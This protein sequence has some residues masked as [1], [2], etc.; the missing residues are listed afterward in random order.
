MFG[1]GFV[2]RG[3]AALRQHV[4]EGRRAGEGKFTRAEGIG[5]VG[6]ECSIGKRIRADDVFAGDVI[7]LFIEIGRGIE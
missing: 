2:R 1:A 4:G 3:C 6:N 5:Q 7:N